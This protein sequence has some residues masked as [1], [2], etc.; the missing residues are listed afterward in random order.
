MSVF[1]SSIMHQSIKKKSTQAVGQIFTFLKLTKT[2][3]KLKYVLDC[4]S[5]TS[6]FKLAILFCHVGPRS[7]AF[8]SGFKNAPE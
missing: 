4:V 1:E 8:N 2:K 6:N 5:Y 7:K 3:L